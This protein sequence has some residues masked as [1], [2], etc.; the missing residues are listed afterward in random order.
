[1][2]QEATHAAVAATASEAGSVPATR[3]ARRSVLLSKPAISSA[4]FVAFVAIFVVMQFTLERG[5]F[6]AVP[7]MLNVHQN[8]PV[9][10]LATAAVVG[11]L[12]GA[13][14]LSISGTATLSTFL[15][16]GLASQQEWNFAVVVVVV[17]GVGVLAGLANGFVVAT[18][19][20]NVIIATLGTGSILLGASAVYSNG[21]VLAATA[22]KP[23]PTWFLEFGRFTTKLPMAVQLIFFV[24]A[25]FWAYRALGR[26]RGPRWLPGPWV[27]WRAG[28]VV[29]GGLV[30]YYALDA[31][32]WL[33][34]TSVL[35]G[36]YL[37]C[38]VLVW[39]L[40]DRTVAGRSMKATG[41]NPIAARL[42]GVRTGAETYR[43]FVATGVLSALAGIALAANQG[44]ASPD[45]A[46]GFLL[47]AFAAAFLSTAIFSR[48]LFTVAGTAIGGIFIVWVAQGLIESG[49]TFT[50]TDVVN[51]AVLIIAVAIS[52]LLQRRVG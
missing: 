42:A 52:A 14:D 35:V 31:R 19:N 49:L 10:L 3:T 36:F 51:G 17:L 23:L 11:L 9:L 28:L 16:V 7:R 37:V 18:W 6:L 5:F 4:T 46:G 30:V 45:V 48:G 40:M 26:T 43:A 1:M 8:V 21:A 38:V 34:A 32:G 47:P 44:S 25:L 24:A 29:V 20:V 2:T 13:F 15:T 39:V 41:S 12:A 50:Y 27:A 22:G 33:A